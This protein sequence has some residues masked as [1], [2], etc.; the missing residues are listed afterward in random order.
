CPAMNDDPASD[1][2]PDAWTVPESSAGQRLDAFVSQCLPAVSRTLLQRSIHEGKITVNGSTLKPS[3]RLSLGE[4]VAVHGVARPSPGPVPEA[5]PLD[6][7]YEDDFLLVVNKPPH[8]V[9]HPAKGHWAGTLASAIAFHCQS[10]S[11]IGG[12]TRPGIVHRLDRDTSGVLVAAKDDATHLALATQFEQRTIEKTY[13]A[14]V[15][16]APDRDRDRIDRPIGPHP[17]HREKMAIREGHPHSR[18]AVTDYT[19][20]ERFRGFGLL[21]ITPHTGRTH[22]IRVHLAHIGHPIVADRLYAGHARLT[23]ADLRGPSEQADATVLI[24]RQALHAW[25]IRFQHPQTGQALCCEVPPPDDFT[26]LVEAMRQA[27]S[28]KRD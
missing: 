2:E 22:Q 17:Y 6:I 20:V 28:V 13:L 27:R 3:H 24:E 25:R 18:P 12:A 15:R 9:V 5:I 23:Q 19:V 4:R 7:V 11:Q 16:G 1:S 21:E 26:R 8:M 14:V 10:L